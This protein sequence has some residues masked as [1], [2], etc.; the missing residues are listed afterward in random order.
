MELIELGIF[1]KQNKVD[2]VDW[3]KSAIKADG[4]WYKLK[5][6]NV[7]G[8]NYPYVC[9]P[10][11]VHKPKRYTK[12][13][14][15]FSE[16]VKNKINKI[17]ENKSDL[18][19]VSYLIGNNEYFITGIGTESIRAYKN[20]SEK[21]EYFRYETKEGDTLLNHLYNKIGQSIL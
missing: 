10:D 16:E 12:R 5:N 19:R 13:L 3:N 20:D 21:E 1:K 2:S 9:V 14:I 15:K 11:V 4:L 6:I 7:G 8:K 18:K 17:N